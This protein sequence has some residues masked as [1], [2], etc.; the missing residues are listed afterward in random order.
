MYAELF[1][2]ASIAGQAT[3]GLSATWHESI[4]A[5]EQAVALRACRAD[6]IPLARPPRDNETA[7][8]MTLNATLMHGGRPVLTAPPVVSSPDAAFKRIALFWSG[9]TEA[10]RAVA[11]ALPFLTRAERVTVLR[12]EEGEWF[13]PTEDLEAFLGYHGINTVVS[14]VLAGKGRTLGGGRR[15]LRRH[16]GDGSLYPF[17]T[18]PA[19]PRQRHRICDGTHGFTGVSLPL[20]TSA[21]Y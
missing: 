3:S 1:S 8:L 16:D 15:Q 10:T 2:A 19:H 5:E 14:K 20:K 18:A 4:G 6:M 17:Q 12:V 11:A 13:A 21:V 9:S 7:T